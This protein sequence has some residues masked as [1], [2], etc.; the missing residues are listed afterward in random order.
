MLFDDLL[1]VPPYSVPE[2]EKAQLLKAALREAFEH[3][4]QSCEP[5]ER[6]CQKHGFVRPPEDFEYCDV[7][8]IPADLFKR[9]RLSSVS[10][11]SIVR[12]LHSSGTS[13]EQ[14]S[15]VVVDNITRTRQ[16]KTL[17]WLLADFLGTQRRPFVIV[18]VD[19]SLVS[20]Q[21]HTISARVA[22]VR[23]FLAAA[24]SASYCMGVGPDGRPEV[25]IDR[26]TEQLSR[27]QSQQQRVVLCGFTYVLYVYAAKALLEKGVAF[28][29]PG[30]TILHIGGWKKLQAEAVSKDVFNSVLQQAFG[31]SQTQIIDAY[32]FTEQLGLVYM[33]CCDGI[34]RC[35]VASEVI[36]RD[37]YTLKPVPDGREGFVE[38]ITPLPHSYPGLAVLVDDIG[39]IVSREPC[40]CGRNGTA[41]E[42]VGRAQRPEIR[43]CGDVF[44]EQIAGRV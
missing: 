31:V 4:V 23:G 30:A 40:A 22:A 12:T 43:G 8:F 10:E 13:S 18:D 29:L 20:A 6:F 3:H 42:I 24:S 44:A 19:P 15:T 33:D 32:G 26:L 11:S 5:F 1:K 35:P 37:P 39:R 28:S 21:E 17:V 14:L 36:V 9:M 34:K 16:V 27:A 41:F 7:P 38:F 2:A 25:D